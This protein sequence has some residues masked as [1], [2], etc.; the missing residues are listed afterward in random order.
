[1][2]SAFV[3]WLLPLPSCSYL[4]GMVMARFVSNLLCLDCCSTVFEVS[5]PKNIST[6]LDGYFAIFTRRCHCHG[7]HELSNSN[8]IYSKT[9]YSL[10]L[11]FSRICLNTP[12]LSIK[13]PY[14]GLTCRQLPRPYAFHASDTDHIIH[15]VAR[16]PQSII[17][18]LT[19]NSADEGL[20]LASTTCPSLTVSSC[21]RAVSS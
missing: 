20:R 14:K 9:L 5:P 6:S 11:P 10:S 16:Y 2:A 18:D 12:R 7:R 3:L 17:C 15:C 13:F 21:R 1:M 8:D 4:S 19:Q